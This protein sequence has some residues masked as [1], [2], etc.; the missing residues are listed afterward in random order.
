MNAKARIQ[1]IVQAA[2][3]S[4][5]MAVPMTLVHAASTVA[6]DQN[7]VFAKGLY[8]I[9]NNT[10]EEGKLV[11]ANQYIRKNGVVYAKSWALTGE[12]DDAV[13][14]LF[15]LSPLQLL[16]IPG[17]ATG[18]QYPVDIVIQEKQDGDQVTYQYAKYNKENDN[19]TI[20][21]SDV[22][23]KKDLAGLRIADYMNETFQEKDDPAFKSLQSSNLKFPN[24]S[25]GYLFQKSMI[26]STYLDFSL[27]EAT[28]Y[29][30]LD[31]WINANE[32]NAWKK[33]KWNGYAIAQPKDQSESWGAVEY[34]G[35]VYQALFTYAGDDSESLYKNNYFFN[36]A[37]YEAVS[38]AI[39]KYYQ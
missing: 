13:D 24:G 28:D 25:I 21:N 14:N 35:K 15:V 8:L 38:E 11:I 4:V 16:T 32:P 26:N 39:K 30:N 36:Q 10:D 29:D 31:A 33:M 3:L 9:D 34:Q 6:N 22:L 37:A 17:N 18:E 23:Q 5:V 20:S 7:S 2:M 12:Y 27:Q 19:S 1:Q